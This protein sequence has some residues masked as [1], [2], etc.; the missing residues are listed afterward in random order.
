M[1]WTVKIIRRGLFADVLRL[2][3]SRAP[4]ARRTADVHGFGKKDER[5]FLPKAATPGGK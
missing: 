4:K 3:T 1:G 5:G 2:G